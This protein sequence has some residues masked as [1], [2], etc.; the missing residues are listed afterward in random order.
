MSKRAWIKIHCEQWLTGSM[1]NLGPFERAIWIDLLVL[2]GNGTYG[3]LGLISL[4]PKIGISDN[5]I[6]SIVTISKAKWKTTKRLFRDL[7][8][9]EVW[10]TDGYKNV[11]KIVNWNKYQSE[12]GRQKSYRGKLQGN[13]SRNNLKSY[14]REV[15]RE[16]EREVDK[17]NLGNFISSSTEKDKTKIDEKGKALLASL[18]INEP[19]DKE[20]EN[21]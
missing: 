10:N 14:T 21:Y 8:M 19:D 6:A 9:I 7:G 15:E 12:Y 2:A 4:T 17:K 13:G 1:R 5:D 20:L 3:D 18:N 16:R 11:I